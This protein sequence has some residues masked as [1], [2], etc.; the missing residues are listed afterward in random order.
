M[1]TWV[2]LIAI[3][4]VGYWLYTFYQQNPDD[5][6]PMVH[7]QKDLV[8][9]PMPDEKLIV[10]QAPKLDSIQVLR[11]PTLTHGKVKEA[12]PNSVVFVCDQGILEVNYDRLAP[13]FEAYY[14][15]TAVQ[16]VADAAAKVAD[17]AAPPSAP[18]PAPKPVPQRSFEDDNNARLAYAS[19]KAALESR[20]QSDLD[21]M[22]KWYRQSNFEPGG[23]TQQQFDTLKADYDVTTLQ[24]NTLVARG[25][26]GP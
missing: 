4:I 16:A 15:P 21:Q 23:M 5:L 10:A 22:T 20:Q 17:Q 3:G 7:R 8:S 12:K 9:S 13:E 11:G 24:L 25:I 2:T 14:A 26:V 6:P 1:K 19:E 18:P